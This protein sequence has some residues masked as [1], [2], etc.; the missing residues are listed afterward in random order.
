MERPALYGQTGVR[1]PVAKGV[2]P[3][4]ERRMGKGSLRHVDLALNLCPL[5]HLP[6]VSGEGFRVCHP[7][8]RGDVSRFAGRG[9]I[10]RVVASR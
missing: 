4:V 8:T 2:P 9:R 7:V 3:V 5:G 1:H 6:P 10:L